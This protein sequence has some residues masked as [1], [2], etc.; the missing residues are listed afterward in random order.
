MCLFFVYCLLFYKRSNIKEKRWKAAPQS[1]DCS[2]FTNC[3]VQFNLR[4]SLLRN[5][6]ATTVTHKINNN[7][8]IKW[9]PNKFKIVL[10]LDLT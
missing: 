4:V 7:H 2:S 9:S 6:N 8:S 3:K 10:S 1:A 5:T